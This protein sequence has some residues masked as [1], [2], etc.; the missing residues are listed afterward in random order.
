MI[1]NPSK[2]VKDYFSYDK[3]VMQYSKL[4]LSPFEEKIFKTYFKNKGKLLDVCCGA[5]R[6]AIKLA[7]RGFE[8]TGV[9]NNIKMLNSGRKIANK[10]NIENIKFIYNDASKIKFK[11]EV[12]DYIIIMDTS[13][14]HI[15][16][17]L[18]RITIIKKCSKF[19][20]KGGVIIISFLPIFYIKGIFNL[21]FHNLFFILGYKKQNLKLNELYFKVHDKKIYYHFFTF[22]EFKQIFNSLNL[23]ISIVSS[24]EINTKNKLNKYIYSF[25][26]YFLHCYVIAEKY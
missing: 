23:K 26:K 1:E 10:K 25:L 15:H 12:F 6:V 13:L 11:E 16:P 5:G 22:K 21:F 2:I 7:K 8:V 3:I 20:K 24:R 4:K 9:D 14:C 19:L 17:E 18:K